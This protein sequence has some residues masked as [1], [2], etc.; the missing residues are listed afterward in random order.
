MV[1]LRIFSKLLF[2]LA[3]LLAV[4]AVTITV[5]GGNAVPALW[6]LAFVQSLRIFL[7]Q[8]NED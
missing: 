5:I 4:V 7:Y 6:L 3:F 8:L 2:V 1:L